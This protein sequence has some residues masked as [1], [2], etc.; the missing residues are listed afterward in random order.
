MDSGTQVIARD[1]EVAGTAS[2]PGPALPG[3]GEREIDG[4]QIAVASSLAPLRAGKQTTFTFSFSEGGAP[5]LDIQAWLGMAGH[6]I[7][8]SEDGATIAHIHA[9]EQAPPSDLLLASGTI[10]GPNIRFVYTFPQPG[11]YRLGAVRAETVL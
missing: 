6:L 1:F 8:R 2:G 10:Y 5:V 4:M 3:L 11:R 7:A 9:A